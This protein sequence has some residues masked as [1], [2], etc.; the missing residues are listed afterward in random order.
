MKNTIVIKFGGSS[1]G[2]LKTMKENLKKISTIITKYQK[3]YKNVVVVVSAFAGETRKLKDMADV[4]FQEENLKDKDAILAFG[5]IFSSSFL[6]QYLNS[7]NIPSVVLNNEKLPILTNNNHG[8]ADIMSVNIDL[9]NQYLQKQLVVVIPGY[10]GKTKDGDLSTLGFDGSDTTAI[11]VASFLKA[12]DCCLFKDVN[13]VYSA[14]PRRVPL[15]KRIER[16]SYEDMFVLSLLG[17]R[18]I[19]PKAVENAKQNNVKVHI[20]PNFM[21]GKGTIVEDIPN[22]TNVVGITY[23]EKGGK[24]QL[25]VVG[26]KL[27][28][29]HQIEKLL[30]NNNIE[31]RL[32]ANPYKEHNISL[33]L[34]DKNYLDKALNILHSF[35]G[36]DSKKAEENIENNEQIYHDPAIK[37]L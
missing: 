11:T 6:G 4:V 20:L 33:E 17:A 9:I 3:S 24:I 14:N 32:I 36:L 34:L 27:G 26:A 22:N 8:N 2:D 16:I 29:K 5:E 25:A 12:D 21:A 37:I 31:V 19:H 35:Y 30:L 10:I 1:M 18:I 15:A 28:D 7:Q 13:G 23:Y